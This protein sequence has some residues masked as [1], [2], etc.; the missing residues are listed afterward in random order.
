MYAGKSTN[1]TPCYIPPARRNSA[2]NAPAPDENGSPYPRHLAGAGWELV[3]RGGAR[4]LDLRTELDR[5]RY[6]E[7]LRARLDELVREAD[8]AP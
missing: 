6:V 1:S 3:G 8:E 4:L 2:V 7:P 5:R